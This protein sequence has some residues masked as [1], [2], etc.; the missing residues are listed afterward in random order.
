MLNN[1]QVQVT[2]KEIILYGRKKEIVRGAKNDTYE[3]KSKTQMK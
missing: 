1:V 3:R 2:K